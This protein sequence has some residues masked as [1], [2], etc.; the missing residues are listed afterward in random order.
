M[1]IGDIVEFRPIGGTSWVNCQI[2]AR[3]LTA[4]LVDVT[5]RAGADRGAVVSAVRV[6]R[7]R[8]VVAKEGH[9]KSPL[10]PVMTTPQR[11]MRAGIRKIL[12]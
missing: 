8:P 9:W 4:A 3:Y 7:L 5:L 12:H 1:Q 2:T 6:D 11:P 10:R